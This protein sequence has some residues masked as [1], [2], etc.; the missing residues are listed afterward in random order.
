MAVEFEEQ[1]KKLDLRGIIITS[2][3][4]A[5][6][7]VVALFWRD[8]ISLTVNQFFPETHEIAPKYIV[9]VLF[10]LV[11][12]V[13]SFG[14]LKS[15]E[16]RIHEF[17]TFQVRAKEK[18]KAKNKDKHDANGELQEEIKNLMAKVAKYQQ[19]KYNYKPGKKQVHIL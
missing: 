3:I 1:A 19:F 13:V 5:L 17:I 6:S 14:L 9:A 12:A 11:A 2:I 4:T 7:F 15:Q 16:I 18:E 10:T 8:A